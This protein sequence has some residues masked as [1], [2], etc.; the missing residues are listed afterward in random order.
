MT[1][2]LKKVAVKIKNDPKPPHKQKEIPRMHRKKTKIAQ[3]K[4]KIVFDMPNIPKAP[5]K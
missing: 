5:P 1:K 3:T 2:M 4:K